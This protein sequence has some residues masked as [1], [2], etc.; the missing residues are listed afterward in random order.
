MVG[1]AGAAG[2]GKSGTVRGVSWTVRGIGATVRGTSCNVRGLGAT[3]CG[4]GGTVRG[5]GIIR[6]QLER[7]EDRRAIHKEKE[8]RKGGEDGSPW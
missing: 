5:I 1:E 4:I 8:G 6:R 3:V 7:G 2:G